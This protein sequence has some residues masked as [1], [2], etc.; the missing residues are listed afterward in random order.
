MSFNGDNVPDDMQ[1]SN[2]WDEDDILC[3]ACWESMTK[4]DNGQEAECDSVEC[5]MIIEL[6]DCGGE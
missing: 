3:P 1:H 5:G 4:S 2:Y 6:I